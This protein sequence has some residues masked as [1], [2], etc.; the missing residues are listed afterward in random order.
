MENQPHS[1]T[2]EQINQM[3]R[4]KSYYPYRIVFGCL[5]DGEFNVYATMTKAKM[6]NRLRKGIPV[7]M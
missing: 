3:H 2:D 4:V 1:I 6:N 7:W 5:E